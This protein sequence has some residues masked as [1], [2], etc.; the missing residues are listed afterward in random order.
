[1]AL[2]AVSDLRERRAPATAE[3]LEAFEVDLMAEFVLARAS[4]GMTDSTV[5]ADVV[6]MEQVRDWFGR[7]LW[8]ME[9]SDADA[10]FGKVLRASP[11]GTRLSRSQSLR[12]YFEFLELRHQVEI[13]ALTGWH[14]S[15]S[16]PATTFSPARRRPAAEITSAHGSKQPVA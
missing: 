14:R 9:P 16:T 12:T 10:Y 1:M 6:N 11:S 2:A 3:E 5:R 13:H 15:A 8:E 4:A 7:P